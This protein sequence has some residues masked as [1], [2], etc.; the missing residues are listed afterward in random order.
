MRDTIMNKIIKMAFATFLALLST[1]SL[2]SNQDFGTIMGGIAGGIIGN[3]IGHGH[4]PV[5]TIGGAVIGGLVGNHVGC[6]MDDS[7]FR[8]QRYYSY[9]RWDDCPEYHHRRYI[10]RYTETFI[11]PYGRICRNAR[12]IDEYGD[13]SYRTVCCR[14]M[15]TSGYCIRWVDYY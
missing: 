13:V 10:P 4:N 12:F 3:N 14:H 8:R 15:T 7:D 9:S 2:A 1:T 5:A 6:S 11:G